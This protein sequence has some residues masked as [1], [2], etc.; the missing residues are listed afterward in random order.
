MIERAGR[1]AL[2]MGML[3]TFAHCAGRELASSSNQDSGARAFG[4]AAAS[5]T[6]EAGTPGASAVV[7][8]S[9]ASAVVPARCPNGGVCSLP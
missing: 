6:G 2:V 9:G 4:D 7:Q 5:G 1:F 8:D 3:V